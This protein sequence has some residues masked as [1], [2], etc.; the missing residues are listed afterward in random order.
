MKKYKRLRIAIQKKGRL[1]N[2]SLRLLRRCGLKV[3]LKNNQLIVHCEDSPV[4]IVCV[5]DDDIPL[6]VGNNMCEL[7]IV[8]SNVFLEKTHVNEKNVGNLKVKSVVPLG[9][10]KCRLS[11][12]YPKT[13]DFDILMQSTDVRVATS[14]PNLLKD[15]LESNTI[16]WTIFPLS[17]SVEVTPLLDMA[18]VICDLV[19]SGKTLED[20]NL[21]E[22]TCLLEC[23]AILIQS[24]QVLE[25][26][27][28]RYIDALLSRIHQI[29]ESR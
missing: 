13:S 26:E 3:D 1:K 6:M 2:E 5:R 25:E 23:E 17:G 4:D 24:T 15:Y 28:A 10:A 27:K 14:Y 11:L 8:G 12:A 18:D 19:N 20:N 21:I 22:K 16:Q 9:F 29:V 7:G